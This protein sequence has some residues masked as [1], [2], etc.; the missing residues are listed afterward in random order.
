[1]S[2]IRIGPVAF[3]G[4][5][6]DE[7][8]SVIEGAVQD[9]QAL[10]LITLNALMY[11]AAT[12]D[13]DLL[14]IINSAGLIVPD[15][16]GIS[17]AI[18]LLSGTAVPRIAGIDLMCR[19]CADS[20][21]KGRRVFLLGAAPGTA[22]AAAEALKTRYPG[23][24]VAGTHHGYF[25]A[26]ETADVVNMVARARPHY[27]FVALDVP[28]QERWIAEHLHAFNAG[29]VMGVGGSFDVISGKLRRA[30]L[31]MQRAGIEWLFRLLQEPRRWRRMAQLP[32]FARE[33]L[34]LKFRGK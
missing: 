2:V 6:I 8:T 34:K 25:T 33:V 26:A 27:L 30:P 9:S 14:H 18:R 3:N 17:A 16:A 23:L 19:L 7:V 1:M 5:S 15:S 11:L 20:V 21:R 29:L 32:V 31:L 22:Q 10:Q 28:R 13:P 4:R 12:R 24:I